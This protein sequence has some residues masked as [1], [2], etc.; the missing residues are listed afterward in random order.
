MSESIQMRTTDENSGDYR[1]YAAATIAGEQ[2]AKG[3]ALH[4]DLTSRVD[5]NDYV[6]VEFS[7]DGAIALE[8]DKATS[9]TVRF[10]SADSEAVRHVYVSPDFLEEFG[11][12]DFDGG[13]TDLDA[14]TSLGISGL[15]SSTEEEYEDDKESRST[16]AEEAADALFGEDDSDDSDE[17]EAD[18]SDEEEDEVAV[19]DEEI[20]IVE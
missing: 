6:E 4:T 20:G 11:D 5:P 3:L 7:E 10:R 14:V 12:F 17:A 1:V 9:A 13:D 2:P 8:A 15:N 18:E 19:S 16:S